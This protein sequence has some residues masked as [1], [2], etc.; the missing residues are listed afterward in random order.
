MLTLKYNKEQIIQLLESKDT[1]INILNFLISHDDKG[2]LR[3]LQMQQGSFIAGG[4]LLSFFLKTL[5]KDDPE[6]TDKGFNDID[7]FVPEEH[8]ES[9]MSVSLSSDYEESNLNFPF[10]IIYKN[11]YFEFIAI[12]SLVKPEFFDVKSFINDFDINA[13]QIAFNFIDNKIYYTD[14]FVDFLFTLELN[15]TQI[16]SPLRTFLRLN[17]K[18]EQFPFLNFNLEDSFQA[19][20]FSRNIED[21]QPITDTTLQRFTK[22]MGIFEKR[23]LIVKDYI[24]SRYQINLVPLSSE[25]EN[26]AELTKIINMQT[27]ETQ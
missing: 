1:I 9:R 20:I 19:L 12:K 16:N 5:Y 18:V 10:K 2:S 26:I 25:E 6:F 22:Y 11:S 21:I 24:N 27:Q 17:R 23:F 3:Y 7:V 4:S 13:C 14:A 15:Y 8:F